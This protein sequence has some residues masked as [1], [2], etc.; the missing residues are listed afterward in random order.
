[1][2][3]LTAIVQESTIVWFKENHQK[4]LQS[5]SKIL[6]STKTQQQQKQHQQHQQQ[7]QQLFSSLQLHDIE[8]S[9]INYKQ[10]IHTIYSFVS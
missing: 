3:S 9:Q 8:A 5:T 2:Q 10:Y 1:M 4:Q 6:F 7:Q